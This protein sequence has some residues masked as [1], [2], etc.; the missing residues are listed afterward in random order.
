MTENQV[1]GPVEETGDASTT[2][3]ENA[4]RRR[5][6]FLVAAGATTL[7]Y[8]DFM[9]Y[10]LVASLIFGQVFF[11]VSNPVMG[12]LLALGSFGV[13]FVARP[14]GG[15]LAG[16]WGDRHGR[17]P[18]LIASMV[19]MGCSTVLVG[20][21]PG[22]DRIGL[23]APVLLVL[24]RLVQGL[25]AGGESGGAVVYG[26]ESAPRNQRGVYGSF[27][28][29]GQSLGALLA[30]VVFL[31]VS[32]VMSEEAL[33]AWGWRIPFLI[34]GVL[35]LVGIV[36]L[37]RTPDTREFATQVE[38]VEARQ[39]RPLRILFRQ[40]P[41]AL[42]LATGLSLGTNGT[43]YILLTY[44]VFYA[45]DHGWATSQ[46]V[47]GQVV[48]T[49]SVTGCILFAGVLTDRFGAAR[50]IVVAGVAMAVFNFV[51]FGAL[52]GESVVAFFVVFAVAGAIDSFITGCTP[53]YFA[54]LFPASARYSG[55]SITYQA[56]AALSGFAPALAVFLYE[57][58]GR[59]MWSGPVL[60]LVLLTLMVTCTVLLRSSAKQLDDTTGQLAP[61]ERS[62]A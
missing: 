7:E 34:G 6:V 46:T 11:P 18:V 19:A 62:R 51:L 61:G 57:V 56:G 27:S 14:L 36:P 40:H 33:T 59:A 50:L 38:K 16:Y 54:S 39:R 9:L 10:G 47:L 43:I 22:Y 17:R 29:M 52:S 45:K 41:R 37:L 44:A 48:L 2:G 26:V 58:S 3:A 12:T 42:L 31:L 25:A 15:V 60:G 5:S 4:R 55:V 30:M 49:A 23:W 21:L 8:Y 35:T 28:G 13:G 53:V 24:L 1:R 32:S 20:L